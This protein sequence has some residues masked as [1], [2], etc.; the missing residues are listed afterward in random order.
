[1]TA[2]ARPLD[3]SIEAVEADGDHLRL[4]IISA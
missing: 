2:T 4:T 1:M 3:A